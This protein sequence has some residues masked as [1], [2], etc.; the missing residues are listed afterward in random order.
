MVGPRETRVKETMAKI[1]HLEVQI[2]ELND[3]VE[4]STA[5]QAEL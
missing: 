2:V 4:K 3:V 5:K 1:P